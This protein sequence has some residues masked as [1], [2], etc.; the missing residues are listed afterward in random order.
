MTAPG[1]YYEGLNGG[2]N[3]AEAINHGD[4]RSAA[5]ARGYRDCRA[6]QCPVLPFKIAGAAM[7]AAATMTMMLKGK[8]QSLGRRR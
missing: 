1:A 4:A 3:V 6:G 5:G 7:A 8:W 2:W